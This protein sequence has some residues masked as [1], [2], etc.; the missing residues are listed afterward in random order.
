MTLGPYETRYF[1]LQSY[2]SLLTGATAG[3]AEVVH[4][5][6]LGAVIGNITNL[7]SLTGESFDAP[8]WSR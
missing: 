1:D 8:L 4:D 3:G 2:E 6:V 5:G 7:N